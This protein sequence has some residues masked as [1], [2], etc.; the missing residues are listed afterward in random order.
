MRFGNVVANEIGMR[1][2]KWLFDS[3]AF[4]SD[5]IVSK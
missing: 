2:E 4:F 3:Q 1:P 5:T